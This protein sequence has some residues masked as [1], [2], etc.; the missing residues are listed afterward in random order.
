MRIHTPSLI[1]AAIVSVAVPLAVYH[2]TPA[3]AKPH[4]AVT[5]AKD[6]AP[7]FQQKCQECH[8]PGSIAPMSLLTYED[9]RPWARSMK[10][11]L[12]LPK[13]CLQPCSAT[14]TRHASPFSHAL[15]TNT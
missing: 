5:Y 9:A 10:A 14:W 3:A 1:A 4:R 11:R 6:I 13:S 15:G 2:P 7:I 8:Q 12:T